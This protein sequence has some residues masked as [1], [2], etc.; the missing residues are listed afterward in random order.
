MLPPPPENHKTDQQWR[1]PPVGVPLFQ[2]WEMA[3]V[4]VTHGE[5]RGV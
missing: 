4:Y 2:W 5:N 3:R 1:P